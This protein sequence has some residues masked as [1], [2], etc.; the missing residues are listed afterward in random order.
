MQKKA[1]S[2][3]KE[4]S[5]TLNKDE[6]YQEI[7]SGFRESVAQ[8]L[9]EFLTT[10]EENGKRVPNGKRLNSES[11][12]QLLIPFLDEKGFDN[13]QKISDE[14]L[15]ISSKSS[16]QPK[17]VRDVILSLCTAIV[18]RY[19]LKLNDAKNQ[20]DA[21]IKAKEEAKLKRAEKAK[22]KKD[23]EKTPILKKV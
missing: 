7:Y 17:E 2:E 3:T 6:S 1:K 12:K 23:A 4:V 10:E 5:R 18:L 20:E 16:K 21:K 14:A 9:E 22:A 19:Q 8:R 13:L 11:K 15:L